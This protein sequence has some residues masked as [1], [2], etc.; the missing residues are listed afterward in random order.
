M[1]TL[2]PPEFRALL[3]G[4]LCWFY[5]STF[6]CC[7]GIGLSLVLYV[8]YLHD[9]RHLSVGFATTLLA[10]NAIAVLIVSPVSGTLTDRVGPFRLIV[11]LLALHA[12]TLVS[13]AFASSKPWIIATSLLMAVTDGAIFGPG[14][15]LLTRL[16]EPDQRQRAYGVNF[17]MVNVGIGLGGLISASVV[18]LA[19][20]TSFSHL[21]LGTAALTLASVLPL[22]PLRRFGDPIERTKPRGHGDPGGWREVLAD[23]QLGR[24]VVTAL[25]LLICGYGSLDAGASLFIVNQ[26]HL[27]V[28]AVGVALFC[29]TLAIVVAQLF[30][31]RFMDGRSRTRMMAVMALLWGLAWLLFG[32]SPHVDHAVALVVLCVAMA[33]FGIGETIWSPVGPA[34][35][36]DLAPEHLRGRYNATFGLLFGLSGSLAPLVAGAFLG[37]GAGGWWPLAIAA[38]CGVGLLGSLNLGRHLTPAQD[39]RV[40][41]EA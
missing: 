23:R 28:G 6:L 33:I 22:L 31:L 10:A 4:P 38:G 7:L 9:I 24:F 2:V 1:T 30:V 12:A 19:V 37:T 39:G 35:V 5:V 20:A 29:N 17:M 25:V 16:V 26:V 32:A 11:V 8:L 27:A 18:S 14:T 13:W 15:V 40:S 34:L 36:N 41:A 21:Y 3:K